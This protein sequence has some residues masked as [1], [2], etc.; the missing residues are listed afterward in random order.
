MCD[1]AV[2]GG[3]DCLAAANSTLSSLVLLEM[4]GL[5]R[6]TN[7]F[8]LTL[9]FRGVAA[10]LGTPLAGFL[11]ERTGGY[12]EPFYLTGALLIT[13]S[14]LGFL[15]SGWGQPGCRQT[16]AAAARSSSYRRAD[17]VDT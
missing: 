12:D 14:G 13:A 1:G 11:A 7:A 15:A 8:G 5:A 16:S 17:S 6:L 2:T 4:V 3:S 10:L 9:L